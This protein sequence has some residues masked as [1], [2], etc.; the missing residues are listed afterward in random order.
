MFFFAPNTAREETLHVRMIAAL[1]IYFLDFLTN[2][3]SLQIVPLCNI[4]LSG[5][6]FTLSGRSDSQNSNVTFSLA[7]RSYNDKYDSWEP[8][9]EPVDGSLR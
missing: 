3:F 8:L 9:I 2:L 1:C 4:S 7:A 6:G 5:I